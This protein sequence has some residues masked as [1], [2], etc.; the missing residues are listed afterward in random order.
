MQHTRNWDYI[1][2]L[3]DNILHYIYCSPS[4]TGKIFF[5]KNVGSSVHVC[6]RTLSFTPTDQ[7]DTKVKD[8]ISGNCPSQMV[9]FLFVAKLSGL[10]L[11]ERFMLMALLNLLETPSS[12]MKP[13]V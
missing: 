1:D 4:K 13:D 7:I 8:I 3:N 11:N 6:K 9:Y 2:D 10:M 5:D 12:T